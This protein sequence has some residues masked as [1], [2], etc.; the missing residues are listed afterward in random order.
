M[1]NFN[2]PPLDKKIAGNDYIKEDRCG[3]LGLE[4]YR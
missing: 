1:L 2:I 3:V 4:Y